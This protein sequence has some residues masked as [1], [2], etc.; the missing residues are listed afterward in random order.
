M[1]LSQD[2]HA[3][4]SVVLASEEACLALKVRFGGTSL[5]RLRSMNPNCYFSKTSAGTL[6]KGS[7]PWP[8][9]YDKWVTGLR[10]DSLRRQKRARRMRE[11]GYLSWRSPSAQ[12]PGVKAERLEGMEG[13]RAYDKETGR[14]AQYGLPQQTENWPTPRASEFKGTG[15][16]GSKSYKHMLDR[17]YL[18]ATASLFSLRVQEMESSQ[19]GEESSTSPRRLNQ[20]F[21]SW[22]MGWPIGHTSFDCSVMAW[23]LWKLRMRTRLSQLAYSH[24]NPESP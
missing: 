19:S 6:L 3:P 17:D 21:V 14:L 18:C 5:K 4:T 16:V 23:S 15:P 1:R 2:T 10:R 9:Q 12:E 22:L 8:V 11:S 7:I 20:R 24:N 13:H